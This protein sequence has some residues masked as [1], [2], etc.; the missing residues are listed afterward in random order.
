MRVTAPLVAALI[1]LASS[2]DLAAQPVV[3]DNWRAGIVSEAR[4]QLQSPD[5]KSVA[6][7]AFNA[8]TYQLEELLPELT[9]A[10][11]HPPDGS[12]QERHAVISA[13]LEAA[14]RTR[15]PKSSTAIT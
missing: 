2:V 5:P 10:L 7:G 3:S 4:R 1:T 8:G 9:T 6:W 14:W 11:V 12:D 13:L 15:E